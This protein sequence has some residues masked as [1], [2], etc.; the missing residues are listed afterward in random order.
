MALVTTP[1]GYP[2]PLPPDL[3][4][5]PADLQALAQSVDAGYLGWLAGFGVVPGSP[6]I[7]VRNSANSSPINYVPPTWINQAC[8]FD[9]LVFSKG[10]FTHH[11]F[12]TTYEQI[13]MPTD[14]AAGWWFVGAA[15]LF[16][17]VAGTATVNSYINAG[18][19]VFASATPTSP[20][21]STVLQG[22]AVE[23]GDD[24]NTIFLGDL[25][26]FPNGGTI[27]ANWSHADAGSGVTKSLEAGSYMWAVRMGDA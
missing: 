20:S 27:S 26:Y 11:G 15:L 23:T 1:E 7:L 5:V 25:A 13:G 24:N 22:E 10:N 12:T 3:A 18:M 21:V 4:A 9:T 8:N 6:C 19:Q 17:Q 2:Y 16:K 14:L